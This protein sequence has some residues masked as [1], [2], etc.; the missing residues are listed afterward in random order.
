[1]KR[2]KPQRDVRCGFQK[3]TGPGLNRRHQDFQAHSG[4]FHR[5]PLLPQDVHGL[6]LVAKMRIHRCPP[7]FRSVYQVGCTL[8][9]RHGSTHPSYRSNI[10]HLFFTI[11]FVQSLSAAS[12][13]SLDECPMYFRR[14]SRAD[15]ADVPILPSDSIA[16][17]SLLLSRVP[18]RRTRD[19]VP[20]ATDGVNWEEERSSRSAW[21]SSWCS[22]SGTWIT[23]CGSS[24]ST[25]TRRGR[26]REWGMYC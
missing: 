10:P 14:I 26:I 12:R 11:D 24:W 17:L 6:G 8:A 3:W 16:A 15:F 23:W 18:A 4:M 22:A 13:I 9:V 5:R 21:T 20:D 19:S 7:M 25:T 1:M 2:K